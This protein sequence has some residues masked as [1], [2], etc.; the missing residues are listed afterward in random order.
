MA[1]LRTEDEV[2]ARIKELEDMLCDPETGEPD[3]EAYLDE[4]QQAELNVLYWF[5]G[6]AG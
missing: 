4:G 3:D 2:R 6:E 1:K 5:L